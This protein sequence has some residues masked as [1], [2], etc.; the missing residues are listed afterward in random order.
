MSEFVN[1]LASVNKLKEVCMYNNVFNV[2]EAPCY[3]VRYR[4]IDCEQ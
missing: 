3:I 1:S 2:V 4:R